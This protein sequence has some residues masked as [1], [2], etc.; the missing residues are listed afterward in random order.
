[1]KTYVVMLAILSLCA[2]GRSVPGA[3]QAAAYVEDPGEKKYHAQ[4]DAIMEQHR[5]LLMKSGHMSKDFGDLGVYI[6]T[7]DWHS[8]DHVSFGAYSFSQAAYDQATHAWFGHFKVI[9][10]SNEL[11]AEDDVGDDKPIKFDSSAIGMDIPDMSMTWFADGKFQYG[12]FSAK[13]VAVKDDGRTLILDKSAPHEAEQFN[14]VIKSSAWQDM[15]ACHMD[16]PTDHTPQTLAI[17]AE[18][19]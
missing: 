7:Y 13:I 15:C 18:V 12:W 8:G 3:T 14:A 11:W 9:E 6:G 5:Q 1:M 17:G 19:K 2:C 4:Q 16:S 10:G